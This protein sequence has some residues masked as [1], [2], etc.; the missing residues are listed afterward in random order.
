M[1][2]KTDNKDV[3]SLAEYITSQR[4]GGSD[5]FTSTL[6]FTLI[7]V[8]ARKAHRLIEK[9]R[10]SWT[11]YERA[12]AVDQENGTSIGTLN[13]FPQ[14]VRDLIYQ[15]V[16]ANSIDEYLEH[17]S[18]LGS[19]DV[20]LDAHSPY[21]IDVERMASKHIQISMCTTFNDTDFCGYDEVRYDNSDILD[22]YHTICKILQ[23]NARIHLRNASPSLKAEFDNILLYQNIFT[24][25]APMRS[26]F[27]SKRYYSRSKAMCSGSHSKFSIS[28]MDMRIL[29]ATTKAGAKL[30]PSCRLLSRA[31]TLCLD[32]RYIQNMILGIFMRLRIWIKL[33]LCLRS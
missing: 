24:S 30:S 20:S 3:L 8:P 13:Y 17:A 1:K 19:M 22:P 7:D 16:Y 27:S 31:S 5:K 25:D 32:A 2:S 18:F 33:W 4:Y 9:V 29:V 15:Y 28:V 10:S 11:W 12:T 23:T 6:P 26:K 14:E 21:I